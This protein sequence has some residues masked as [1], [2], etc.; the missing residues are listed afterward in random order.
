LGSISGTGGKE[1]LF[2]YSQMMPHDQAHRGGFFS[3]WPE[4]DGPDFIKKI[5]TY[6][7]DKSD[8][9]GIGA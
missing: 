7:I 6:G 3:V 2:T 8:L 5:K 9:S 1:L 4:K